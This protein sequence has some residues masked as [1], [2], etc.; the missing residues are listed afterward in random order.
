MDSK[1]KIQVNNV[2]KV[3]KMYNTSLDKM[4]EAFSLSGKVLHT[5][6]YAISNL[7]FS[8]REGEILGIMGRNGSG[9]STLLKM[10]TGILEPSEGNIEV[11]GKISSLLEL[12]TGFNME[13]TGIE[14]V[15][16]YGTL[17]GFTKNQMEQK[18][19]GIIDFAE[20]G[21]YV[22]QP[23][24]T[25]SSGMFA[26]LAF[27]C[28]I[29]VEPNIL[30]VDEILSVGDIRFQAKCFN[31]FKEFQKNGVTILYV[32]HDV[33][34]MRTFCDRAMWINKGKLVDIGD[35]TFISAKY[36]E[37]MYLD[38]SDEFTNYK[39]LKEEKT[40]YGREIDETMYSAEIQEP[41]KPDLKISN[42]LFS[43]SIAHWGSKTGMIKSVKILGEMGEEKKYF[44]VSDKIRIV[45]IFDVDNE[46]DVRYFSVAFSIKNKEGTDVI[47]KTTYDEGIG[48]NR[49]ENQSIVFEIV[50]QLANGEYYLVAALENR[51]KTAISYYEY[52]EGAVFF[53]MYTDKKIYGMFDVKTNVIYNN[54]E[55]KKE[56]IC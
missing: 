43:D 12:G 11:S 34:M 23:V 52:I 9:K 56:Q 40:D 26:R 33:N 22:Y 6:F 37:F 48:I 17:M 41:H 50:L 10:I 44:S 51:E 35:P 38:E 18:L 25:Y 8:V 14:N 16:F 20:I 53:K 21:D 2:S 5:D 15:F 32:G 7:S 24:K 42:S 1:Y 39:L 54:K 31:K 36:T 30:I 47:V 3:F 29:N 46:I 55:V 28:A 49:G 19:Q 27:S 13:Y 45:I 4:R